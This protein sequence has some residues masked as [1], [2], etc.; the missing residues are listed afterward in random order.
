MA[1][2]PQAA[3]IELARAF[4]DG[5]APKIGPDDVDHLLAAYDQLAA[6]RETWRTKALEME[7]DRDRL[8]DEL[9]VQVLRTEDALA[10]I[11]RVRA[12]CEAQGAD[13]YVMVHALRAAIGQPPY[14]VITHGPDEAMPAE[15][16]WTAE[17]ETDWTARKADDF[18][19]SAYVPEQ[20]AP[21][22]LSPRAAEFV[23]GYQATKSAIEADR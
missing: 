3:A 1:S 2:E 5:A 22:F 10:A 12:L 18:P 13:S 17:D 7:A 11:G 16:D 4:A 15:L 19:R 21:G 8:A 20:W 6:G 9:A 14:P 23:S